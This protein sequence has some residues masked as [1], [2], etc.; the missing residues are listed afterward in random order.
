MLYS[1]I[2]YAKSLKNDLGVQ[3]N[4]I[5]MIHSK[6]GY[7]LCFVIML[8]FLAAY[9]TSTVVYAYKTEI[10]GQDLFIISVFLIGAIFVL[11]MVKIMR[12]VFITN[13]AEEELIREAGR[14]IEEMIRLG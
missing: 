7:V 2:S 3:L 1:I 14:C 5:E 11:T 13:R 9:A 8:F 12:N 4:N 6:L 10:T